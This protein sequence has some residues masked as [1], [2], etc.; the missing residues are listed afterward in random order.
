[1]LISIITETEHHTH[2]GVTIS[3]NHISAAIAKA[4]KLLSL[5]RRCRHILLIMKLYIK[6]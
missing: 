3:N 2:L 1:M 4:E 6:I 5:I